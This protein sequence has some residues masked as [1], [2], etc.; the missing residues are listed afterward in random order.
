MKL[1]GILSEKEAANFL[2]G[3]LGNPNITSYVNHVTRKNNGNRRA[4]HAI[5]PDIHTMNFPADKQSIHNSGSNRVA[6]AIFEVNTFTACKSRYGY[7]NTKTAPVDRRARM[8]VS[9][10]SKKFKTLDVNFSADV[11]GDGK[12]DIKGPFETAQQQFHHGQ[13]ILMCAG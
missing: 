11:V 9:S 4:Q 5:V 12:G 2:L 7:N 6:E 10:Y 1:G 3:K 8:I 13:V